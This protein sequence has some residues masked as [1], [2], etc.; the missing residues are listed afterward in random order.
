MLDPELKLP[1]ASMASFD[2]FNFCQDAFMMLTPHAGITALRI[3]ARLVRWPVGASSEM[4]QTEIMDI[5]DWILAIYHNPSIVSVVTSY[6]CMFVCACGVCDSL[7]HSFSILNQTTIQRVWRQRHHSVFGLFMCIETVVGEALTE[8]ILISVKDKTRF[9]MSATTLTH[10]DTYA[11]RCKVKRD[12]AS[13]CN[14]PKLKL[15]WRKNNHG[16]QTSQQKAL[17]D[18]V[19]VSGQI[20]ALHWSWSRENYGCLLWQPEPSIQWHLIHHDF[21]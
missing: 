20:T 21:P 14:F 4:S 8:S 15:I 2:Q 11:E 12:S 7:S 10:H 9:S 1:I 3:Y 13:P 18:P 19:S 17:S 5:V 16:K 6:M